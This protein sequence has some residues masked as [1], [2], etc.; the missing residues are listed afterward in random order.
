MTV[1]KAKPLAAARR[2]SCVSCLYDPACAE[3][4]LSLRPSALTTYRMVAKLGLPS[5]ESAVY[6]LS[7]P[8]PVSRASW[9]IPR[10]RA[11]VLSAVNAHL[12]THPRLPVFQAREP[13]IEAFR[14]LNTA[15]GLSVLNGI[16][17]I[18][19]CVSQALFSA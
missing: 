16:Q 6:R 1:S 10:A 11:M 13:G 12:N 2:F 5:P 14:G 7:R 3:P 9:L 15:H 8:R 4:A 18:N 19:D 17:T